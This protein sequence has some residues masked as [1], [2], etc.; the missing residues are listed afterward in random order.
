MIANAIIDHA[1]LPSIS[2]DGCSSHMEWLLAV[3]WHRWLLSGR[4]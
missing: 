2:V 4:Q 3:G 1:A